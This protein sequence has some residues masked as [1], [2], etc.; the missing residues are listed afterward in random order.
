MNFNTYLNQF[1]RCCDCMV[2]G[3]TS[4]Y[5]RWVSVPMTIKVSCW[6]S[7]CGDNIGAGTAIP[8]GPPEFIPGF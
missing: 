2:V 5:A 3:F 4:T 8:S 6:V 1:G 7:A